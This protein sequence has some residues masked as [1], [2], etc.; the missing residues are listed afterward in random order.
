MQSAFR[1][2]ERY[3]ISCWDAAIL[4]AAA[5]AGCSKLL[6]EDLNPVLPDLLKKGAP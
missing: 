6:S 5:S 1:I 3:Q 2:K 4:A